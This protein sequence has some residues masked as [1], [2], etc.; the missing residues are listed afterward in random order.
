MAWRLGLLAFS[1]ELEGNTSKAVRVYERADK[2]FSNLAI[3]P[4]EHLLDSNN[5]I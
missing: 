3:K 1:K 5:L 4:F 2:F